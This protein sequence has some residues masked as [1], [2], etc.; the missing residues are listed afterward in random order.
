MSKS[1]LTH[2]FDLPWPLT[3]H[4]PSATVQVLFTLNA[5]AL[6]YYYLRTCRTDPGFIKATEEEK[7][8]VGGPFTVDIEWSHFHNASFSKWV[9][10]FLFVC[11][12]RTFCRWPKPAAWTPE[13]SA[14]PAWWASNSKP[15]CVIGTA[16]ASPLIR[17][18]VC[19]QR[20]QWEPTTA[21]PAT[22]AWRSTT[23]TPCGSIAASVRKAGGEG[24]Q[25]WKHTQSCIQRVDDRSC[26]PPGK[27]WG[28]SRTVVF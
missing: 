21:S 11:V 20:N 15:W 9:L 6:L 7:K 26:H 1:I 10:F 23:T 24:R 3:P 25:T 8:M 2:S 28:V 5:T 27:I 22:P 18:S 17:C 19:R 13:F 16:M 14:L 4:G 12:V